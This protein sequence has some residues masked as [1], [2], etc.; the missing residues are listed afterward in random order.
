MRVALF[1]PSLAGGGAERVMSILAAGF[2][3][4]GLDVDLVLANATGPY[5][6]DIP[7]G[8]RVIDLKCRHVLASLPGLVLYLRRERP[9]ALLS[10]LFRA[11]VIAIWAKTLS[12]VH[13]RMVIRQSSMI[14]LGL[15][16]GA[17]RKHKLITRLLLRFC[18]KADTIVVSSD[19][20]ADELLH[21]AKAPREIVRIIPNPISMDSLLKKVNEPLD[22]PWFRPG[23]PPVILGVGRLSPEKNF[24]GLVDAFA[25]VRRQLTVRLMIL[26][27][28]DLRAGLEARI[29]D[30]GL[31]EN[32]QLPGFEAN[33]YKY[34]RH[35]AV[36]VLPSRWEGFPNALVEAMA[37][38]APVV[39]T[40][41]PGASEILENGRWG[42]L[43]PVG[44]SDALANAIK[45]VVT[46]KFHP[47]VHSRVHA[48]SR[49][50]IVSQYMQALGVA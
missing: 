2:L 49:G 23:E 20:M 12:R 44:D 32:V 22:H 10:T 39:A 24:A 26:G 40:A 33:P 30:R 15:E 31:R 16:R 37:C 41:C 18:S 3:E 27:D 25:K 14:G 19:E 43:V 42:A 8:I 45:V 21:F 13:V 35:A 48:Y 29:E 47:D 17:P 4:H 6:A 5:L 38:G 46:A 9:E 28:G 50:A 34:M 11:N 1:C 7:A 36:F